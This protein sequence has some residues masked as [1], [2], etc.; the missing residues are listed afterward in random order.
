MRSAGWDLV[1]MCIITSLKSLTMSGPVSILSGVFLYL[2][3]GTAGTAPCLL[4]WHLH[5]LINAFYLLVAPVFSLGDCIF[6]LCFVL[7]RCFNVPL[8]SASPRSVRVLCSRELSQQMISTK[9]RHESSHCGFGPRHTIAQISGNGAEHGG[10]CK[11]TVIWLNIVSH[12]CSLC[13]V[14]GPL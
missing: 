1:L 3:A 12:Y 9:Q 10:W 5:P 7:T 8:F 13:L 11:Q 4:V 6:Y 14:W 2:S